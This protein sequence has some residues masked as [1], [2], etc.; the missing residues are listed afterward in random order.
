MPCHFEVPGK[1]DLIRPGGFRKA[2]LCRGRGYPSGRKQVSTNKLLTF[3]E[4]SRLFPRL[5]KRCEPEQVAQPRLRSSLEHNNQSMV[6]LDALKQQCLNFLP[7]PQGH[8]EFLEIFSPER[9]VPLS[10][11]GGKRSGIAA[12]SRITPEL[13]SYGCSTVGQPWSSLSLASFTFR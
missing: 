10:V 7:L 12:S 2:T 4:C 13:N 5:E 9:N 11:A 8:G 1:S 3:R 6:F